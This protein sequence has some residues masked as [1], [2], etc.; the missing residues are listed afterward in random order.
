MAIASE[1]RAP[2]RFAIIEN[3]FGEVGVD[4]GVLKTALLDNVV[5]VINGCICCTVRGAVVVQRSFRQGTTFKTRL[6]NVL[7]NVTRLQV[8]ST[9]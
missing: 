4:D 9:C 5:E 3:E 8:L 6:F 7:R 1:H 2:A